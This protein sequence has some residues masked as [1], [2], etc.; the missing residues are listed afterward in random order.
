MDEQSKK[1]IKDILL[2]Y[3][4]TLLVADPRRCEPK[5]CV[6]DPAL[7]SCWHKWHCLS[8]KM[9]FLDHMQAS[10]AEGYLHYYRSVMTNWKTSVFYWD[11]IVH[12][13][14]LYSMY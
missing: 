13:M 10:K 1:E 4:R 6:T 3:D 14:C 12:T 8:C 2:A 11:L 5:K 9:S 7:V